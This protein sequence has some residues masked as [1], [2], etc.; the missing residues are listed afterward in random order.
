MREKVPNVTFRTTFI[1]GF[2]GETDAEYR[3]LVEFVRE[4]GSTASAPSPTARKR[5][6]RPTTCPTRC[7]PEVKKA[8]LDE[9]MYTQRGISREHNEALVGREVEVLVEGNSDESELVWVGRIASRPPRSTAS[10]TSVPSRR[11]CARA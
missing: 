8:R 1:V 11:T 4:A 9:L 6:R 3:E 10:P 5:A 2:P 7:R